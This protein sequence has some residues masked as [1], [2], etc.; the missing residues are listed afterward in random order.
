MLMTKNG[1]QPPNVFGSAP[2]KILRNGKS[3]SAPNAT[4]ASTTVSGGNS[5]KPAPIK[6]NEAPHSTDSRISSSQVS[7][8]HRQSWFRH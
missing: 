5:R 3:P 2:P 6:K 4:R 8:V 1:I 7:T